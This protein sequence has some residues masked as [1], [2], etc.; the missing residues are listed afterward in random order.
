MSLGRDGPLDVHR[1]SGP[2]INPPPEKPPLLRTPTLETRDETTSHRP[3]PHTVLPDGGR[4]GD[5]VR[6]PFPISTLP[7]YRGHGPVRRETS[8]D[9]HD[10]FH[11]CT[12]SFESRYS[13]S[14][15]LERT[16]DSPVLPSLSSLLSQGDDRLLGSLE[17]VEVRL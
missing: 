15:H 16:S 11:R 7:W 2:L 5:G 13:P 9:S 6:D 3:L 14:S 10:P 1:P 17:L 4:V 8:P 12:E